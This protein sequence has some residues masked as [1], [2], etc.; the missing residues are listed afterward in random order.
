MARKVGLA[1]VAAA[2]LLAAAAPPA[3]TAALR[4]GMPFPAESA[5]LVTW[6]PVL[7]RTPNRQWRRWG[8]PEVVLRVQI[9]LR[10]F[11]LAHPDGPRVLVGDLSRPRGG[12][13]GAR[14]G[15]LGHFSH[16]T[17]L[18]VDVYYP[19]RDGLERAAVRPGQVDRR[20]AQELVDRFLA[21]GAV[22]LFVGPSLR[23]RGPRRRVVPLVHHD[24]HVHV[25][26]APG[27]D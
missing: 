10:E 11:R 19:R 17:G 8:R 21:W 23:L 3:R 1:I 16:Q 18:D 14:F 15:G 9:V 12:P 13:F 4:G 5:D 2:A 22:K 26:F 27:P 25:R 6:D 7:E 20:L 24:D